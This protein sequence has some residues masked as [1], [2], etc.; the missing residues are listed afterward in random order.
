M[1][2][3]GTKAKNKKKL[4]G[5][6]LKKLTFLTYIATHQFSVPLF[7][8]YYYYYLEFTFY[9]KKFISIIFLI[10]GW[11]EREKKSLNSSDWERKHQLTL[12]SNIKMVDFSIYRLHLIR[13]ILFGCP[14]IFKLLE[15]IALNEG[16]FWIPSWIFVF[17]P[18]FKL[19][20]DI[21]KFI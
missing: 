12:I 17:G 15:K 10:F 6:W 5:D 19:F 21:N 3:C 11:D 20:E 8:Y 16:I 7:Y 18:L 1:K 4:H 9:P 14:F 13:V 2:R